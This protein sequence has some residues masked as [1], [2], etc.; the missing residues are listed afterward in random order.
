MTNFTTESYGITRFSDRSSFSDILTRKG[1][2][3][4][5]FSDEDLWAKVNSELISLS[6]SSAGHNNQGNIRAP[7]VNSINMLKLIVSD[8]ILDIVTKASPFIDL[9]Q[10]NIVLPTLEHGQDRWHRDIPYQDWVPNGL[11][12]LNILFSF[13][14]ENTS[15]A[16]LEILEGSHFVTAF[17]SEQSMDYLTKT[18]YLGQYEFLIMNSFMFHR[19]PNPHSNILVNQ[20]FAPKIFKQQIDLNSHDNKQAILKSLRVLD[21]RL[22]SK[23]ISMLGLDRKTYDQH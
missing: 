9:N 22:N 6:D 1:Y 23:V 13:S 7:L 5:K 16:S 10:Q 14:A 11:A 4:A 19:A 3:I 18:V 17:P 20:V 21:M 12:A 15:S 8:Q 2:F